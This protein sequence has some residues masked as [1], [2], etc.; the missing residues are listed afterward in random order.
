MHRLFL[1]LRGD[2]AR[3]Q[4]CSRGWCPVPKSRGRSYADDCLFA[5]EKGRRIDEAKLIA[6]ITPLAKESTR[7]RPDFAE[8]VATHFK[9]DWLLDCF[10]RKF[11]VGMP[12]T[13][14]TECGIVE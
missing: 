13:E 6:D 9:S 10:T 2:V 12:Y 14:G 8:L 1:T 5:D 11:F 7:G 4:R 3:E